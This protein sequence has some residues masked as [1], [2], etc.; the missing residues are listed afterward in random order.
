MIRPTYTPE[1][2]AKALHLRFTEGLSIKTVAERLGVSISTL[3]LW[4]KQH[5][6]TQSATTLPAK[7]SIS[8]SSTRRTDRCDCV[9]GDPRPCR[10]CL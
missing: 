9:C 1:R 3:G 6:K 10:Y 5:A 4:F 7:G 8:C 2:Q